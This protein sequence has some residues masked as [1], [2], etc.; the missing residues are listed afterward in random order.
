LDI[1]AYE[2]V[3]IIIALDIPEEDLNLMLGRLQYQVK[4]LESDLKD[5]ANLFEKTVR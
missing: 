2:L 4:Q 1:N 3:L 5:Q